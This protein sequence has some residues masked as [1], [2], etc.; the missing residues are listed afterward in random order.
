MRLFVERARRILPTFRPTGDE[1]GAIAELYTQMGG[2]SLYFGKPHPPI[3]QMARLR[4]TALIG[5]V[6]LPDRF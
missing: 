2:T 3:Y 1:L 4:L 6:E 5:P